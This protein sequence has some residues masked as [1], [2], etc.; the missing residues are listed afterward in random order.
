M[1]FQEFGNVLLPVA[2]EYA[3]LLTDRPDFYMSRGVPLSQFFN[4]DTRS[5]LRALWAALFKCERACEVLRVTL[6]QRPYFNIKQAFSFMDRDCD[7][8]VDLDDVREFLANTGFYATERELQGIMTKCD[9][10]NNGRISFAEFVD[11][12][13]PKLGK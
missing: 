2:K 8:Y 9:T 13:S 6:R 4:H 12:F 1:N 11:E 3:A 10:N 7:G 5:E